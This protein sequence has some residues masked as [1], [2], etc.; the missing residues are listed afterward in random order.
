ME[1]ILDPEQLQS[2]LQLWKSERFGS[3]ILAEY[4]PLEVAAT[5]ES[6]SKTQ[7][8]ILSKTPPS[9][10]LYVSKI[11]SDEISKTTNP[12]EHDK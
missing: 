3:S 9:P 11:S 12:K 5:R 10:I 4:I 8:L 7:S 2:F 1:I 6:P